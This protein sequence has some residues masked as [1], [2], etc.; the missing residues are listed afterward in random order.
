MP[1]CIP[2]RQSLSVT[3]SASGSGHT[4]GSGS[5]SGNSTP[6]F[7]ASTHTRR[8]ACLSRGQRRPRAPKRKG[9][10]EHDGEGSYERGEGAGVV[11]RHICEHAGESAVTVSTG[12]GVFCRAPRREARLGSA[13]CGS[14]HLA[15]EE[16]VAWRVARG[17]CCK[18]RRR[19]AATLP[20]TDDTSVMLLLCGRCSRRTAQTALDPAHARCMACSARHTHAS[21]GHVWDTG[22]QEW[23]TGFMRRLTKSNMNS[24]IPQSLPRTA[25]H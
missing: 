13:R 1:S 8:R 5:A 16:V 18:G 24:G 10:E 9:G 21:G 17:R 11:C 2:R 20:I 23:R 6:S 14:A 15:L 12:D 7:A 3:T 19:P 25:E 22:F 4:E